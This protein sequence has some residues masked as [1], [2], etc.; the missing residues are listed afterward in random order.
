ML[1]LLSALVVVAAALTPGAGSVDKPVRPTDSATA[2]AASTLPTTASSRMLIAGGWAMPGTMLRVGNTVYVGGAF[3]QIANRTGSAIVVPTSGG[4]PEPG[5]PEVAGGSVTASVSDETSGWY[6]SGSFTN[7]GGVERPG[8][9]HVRGDDT[10]DPAFAPGELGDVRALALVGNVLYAGGVQPGTYLVPVLK[11]L[12]ATTGD[13][14]P[15]TFDVPPDARNLVA[16]IATGNRLYVAFGSTMFDSRVVAFDAATGAQLWVHTFDFEASHEGAAALALDVDRTKVLVGGEFDDAGNE[17]L[18]ALDVSTG[19]PTGP[20]L[21]VPTGVTSIAVAVNDAYVARRRTTRGSSGL[22]VINLLTGLE[23]SWGLIRAERLIVYG[24]MLYVAGTTAEDESQ[25][26]HAR[27]YSAQVSPAKAKAVLKKVSPPL[28]GTVSTLGAQGGRLFV[29][30]TF[31]SAGGVTRANLA[32]F[33]V[34]TGKLLPWRPSV[35]GVVT[36]LAATNGKI[37][38]GGYFR[39]VAG[40]A[41]HGLAAVA[42]TGGGRLLPWRPALSF[43][44][45]ISLSIGRGRVFVGGT[46]IPQGEK[47]APGKPIRFTHL[48]AFSA[49]GPGARIK[50]ASHAL[51]TASG[52]ALSAGGVLAVRGSTLVLAEPSRVAAFS[53]TGNGQHELW[54]RPVTGTVTAFATS[55]TTLYLGGQFSQVGG[56]PRSNLAALALGRKGAL[57]SFAPAVTEHVG[58]LAPLG[59]VLVYSVA[60]LPPPAWHQALGAVAPD[61][62]ILPWRFDADGSVD[63]IAPF[64]GGLAVAGSFDWLGP[65]GHQAAGRFGWLR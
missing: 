14:L 48:A 8:L 64:P 18:E 53:V 50:F 31:S 39:H 23:K 63:C 54:R 5:F 32:A 61:G 13:A 20:T 28:G 49:S 30:G 17:N 33:D 42:A 35:D 40:R 37:Y 36:G 47:R 45:G 57:L 25:G 9:A 60:S 56:Q 24:Q 59:G 58:A 11:A 26:V 46:F 6:I 38:L 19:L 52:G 16:L 3:S 22:D 15:I 44:S 43:S 12:D 4:A 2:E 34:R 1:R 62:T 29:A 10:L 27:V 21:R 51:N 7:V 55:G 41:R 65:A